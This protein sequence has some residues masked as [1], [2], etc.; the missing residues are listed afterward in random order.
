MTDKLKVLELLRNAGDKG[1]H[2]FELMRDAHSSRAQARV[3]DLKKD[4]Y[5]ISAIPEKMGDSLGVRYFL[6]AEPI[7][8]EPVKPIRWEFDMERNVARPVYA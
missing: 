2:S 8:H 5:H 6:N 7:K 4:G 3:C 1:I